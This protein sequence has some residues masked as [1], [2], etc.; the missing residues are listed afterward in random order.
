MAVQHRGV[1]GASVVG[2]GSGDEEE[3]KEQIPN[4]IL[5]RLK[6]ESEGI[7]IQDFILLLVDA[8]FVVSGRE[9]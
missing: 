6:S 2:G 3:G 9:R 4:G 7:S 1:D 8:R 5:S